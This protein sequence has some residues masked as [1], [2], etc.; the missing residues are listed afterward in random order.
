MAIGD[1]VFGDPRLFEDLCDEALGLPDALQLLYC[2]MFLF[3]YWLH[4]R[5]K[6]SAQGKLRSSTTFVLDDYLAYACGSDNSF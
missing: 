1:A 6:I 4:N 5:E 3:T 2:R